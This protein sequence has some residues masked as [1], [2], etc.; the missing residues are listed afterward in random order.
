MPRPRGCRIPRR[1]SGSTLHEDEGDR[2]DYET[3]K[4]SEIRFTWDDAAGRLTVGAKT[5]SYSGMPTSRTFNV[6]WVGPNHGGG[7][8][9]SA[10]PDQGVRY[11]GS[12]VTVSAK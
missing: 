9:T 5:G 11:D 4:Y 7:A 3:G 12:E 6:V 1:R 10:E 2:G 8:E